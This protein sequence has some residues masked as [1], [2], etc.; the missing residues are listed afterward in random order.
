M[1]PQTKVASGLA[2]NL[3]TFLSV[4]Q[5]LK[6]ISLIETQSPEATLKTSP[7]CSVLCSPA[8]IVASTTSS[9]Y[10]KSL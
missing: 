8:K 4:P 1:F 5:I 6:A 9:T 10:T 7:L 3:F 2:G